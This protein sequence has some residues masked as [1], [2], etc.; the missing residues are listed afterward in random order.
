MG[1]L[2]A[3]AVTA[4]GRSPGQDTATPKLAGNWT[5]TW[6]DALGQTHRHVL[7]V[8]GVGTKL[9][10]RELFDGQPAVPASNLKLD[11][12]TIRFTVVRDQ[13][14]ADY[15]GKVADADLI[16][17]TVSV[18]SGGGQPEEFVWKAERGK[19]IAK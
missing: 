1:L 11:G 13:R 2:V 6:K 16:N 14:K 10:A 18:S 19:E 15:N 8:E 12:K 17:G 7:E 3:S 9:A 4:V 5:W